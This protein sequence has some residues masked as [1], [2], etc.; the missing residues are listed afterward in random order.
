MK[1]FFKPFLLLA[2]AALSFAS[3]SKNSDY[4]YD[5]AREQARIEDSLNN[6][7]IQEVIA[8]QALSLEKFAKEKFDN[9]VFN[10]SL[11]I[12]FDIIAPGEA[13]PFDYKISSQGVMAPDVTVIY[14][15]T[16]LDGTVFDQS[17]KES[18]TEK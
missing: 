14:K 4:D 9:P 17:D 3:C 13:K 1:T 7:R 16:L 2:L 8:E 12:W 11:G 6:I 5:K 10:D 18:T 15:G